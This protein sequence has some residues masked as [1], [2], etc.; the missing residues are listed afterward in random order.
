VFWEHIGQIHGHP[1]EADIDCSGTQF[2]ARHV[3]VGDF[4]G[5]GLTEV[6]ASPDVDTSAGNDFWVMKYDIPSGSWQHMAPIPNHPIGADIDCSS[7]QFSA[8][9]VLV[10]DF[11][12]DGCDEIVVAPK[13]DGSRGNDLWVMK[14]DRAAHAW[15]HMAPIANHAMEADID[16][17][18]T[19][20]PAKLMLAGDF[21]NDGRAEL[22]VVPDA[23]GS[24]GNDI[25]VMKY[26]GDYPTGE[27]RHMAPIA[28]HPMQ[29]DIDCSPLQFA[30][31]LAL[32]GDFDDDG[33]DELVVVPDAHDSRGNDL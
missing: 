22:V 24:R 5:D 31:K 29:A 9:L 3:V 18:N 32:V 2:A 26:V 7:T 33:H 4:D 30:T 19:Q 28:N 10:A 12:G 23:P 11:D 17:S 8:K 20:F 25:W 1:M 6:A 15:R 14:F 21:D 13:A 16:C 27:W